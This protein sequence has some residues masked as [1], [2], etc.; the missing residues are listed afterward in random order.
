MGPVEQFEPE[1]R[2]RTNPR[3]L[4]NSKDWRQG[5]Q[6]LPSRSR[7]RIPKQGR[8][9]A[10]KRRGGSWAPVIPPNDPAE[11][12]QLKKQICSL[13][14]D[15]YWPEKRPN[16]TYNTRLKIAEAAHGTCGR[17]NQPQSWPH[18]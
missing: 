10:V 17:R 4:Q 11:A 15:R 8:Q 16:K 14:G 18:H 2:P 1:L 13:G 6:G 12:A 5:S 9:T 7:I 3:A